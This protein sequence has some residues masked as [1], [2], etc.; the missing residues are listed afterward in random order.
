[1]RFL[2]KT[3]IFAFITSI[4]FGGLVHAVDTSTMAISIDVFGNIAEQGH[5]VSVK[6]DTYVLTFEEFDNSL[7]GVIVDD[8]PLLL[9]DTS[10]EDAKYVVTSGEAYVKVTAING[11]IKEGDYITSS[12]IPGFGQRADVSG[13]I[14]GIALE[15]F[16]PEDPNDT[17]E[18]L[19][20]IDVASVLLS[21]SV[22]ADLIEL[23]RGGFKVPFLTPLTSLRYILAA[24][25]VLATF[26]IGFS[27]F[28]KISG[29]SIEALGR[30]P[31]ASKL[32]RS[33]V[34]LNFALTTVIIVVG[35]TVAYLILTL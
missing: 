17:G 32:I 5:I 18:V 1:M 33:A 28:G 11:P 26:I 19:V 10:L 21:E 9:D 35:L 8:P 23:L 4:F 15:S 14:L 24:F 34:V 3:L 27:S 22:E 16:E 12:Q 29:T 2:P 31:L 7:F 13:R 6:E 25:V 20:F 30:N